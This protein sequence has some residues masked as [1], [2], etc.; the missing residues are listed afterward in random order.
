MNIQQIDEILYQW[1]EWYKRRSVGALGYPKKSIYAD[2][3]F[4]HGKGFRQ[5]EISYHDLHMITIDTIIAKWPICYREAIRIKYLEV[6]ID[7][8]KARY[9]SNSLKTYQRFVKTGQQ[10]IIDELTK[11]QGKNER[12]S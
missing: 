12:H 8:T 11:N 1:A 2:P 3:S 7:E 9:F 6:G 10:M 5:P 4:T